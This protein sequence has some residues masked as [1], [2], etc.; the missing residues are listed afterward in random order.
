MLE[1]VL[2]PRETVM[3]LEHLHHNPVNSR[4]ILQWTRHDPV[5]SRVHQLTLN[6]WLHQSS[7]VELHL[8]LTWKGELTIEDGRPEVVT[9]LHDG[10]P[11]IS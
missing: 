7:H 2:V 11:G 1:S 9:E 3:L 10:H 4:H 8:Y 6:K 5:L